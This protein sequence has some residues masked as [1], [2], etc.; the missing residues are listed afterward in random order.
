MNGKRSRQI[1]KITGYVPSE[2]N[3]TLKKVYRR[4]K[5]QYKELS[6]GARKEFLTLLEELYSSNNQQEKL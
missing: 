6:K 1:R 3:Q 2:H 4:A 5:K